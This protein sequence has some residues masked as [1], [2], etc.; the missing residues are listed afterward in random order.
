MIMDGFT[1]AAI[2]TSGARIVVAHGEG[3]QNRLQPLE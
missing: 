2:E 1:R 3:C